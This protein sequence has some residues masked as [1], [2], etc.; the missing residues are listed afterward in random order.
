MRLVKALGG[1]IALAIGLIAPS[2]QA[3]ETIQTGLIGSPQAGGWPYYIAIREGFFADNGVGLD[4]IYV[5]TASG[6]VQQ[7]AAGSLDVVNIGIVEPIHAIAR[8]EMV[9]LLCL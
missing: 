3:L 4:I 6:L 9:C 8:L 1:L 7:L 5:P 2:A